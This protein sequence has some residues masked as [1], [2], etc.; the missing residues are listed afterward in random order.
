MLTAKE[1]VILRSLAQ[2]MDALIQIGK[3]GISE[4][5]IDSAS[6]ILDKREL[7][8]VKILRNAEFEKEEAMEQLC[9][10]LH[11]EPVQMIGSVLVIYRR[12]EKKDV[13][14]II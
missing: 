12:S 9:A 7:L 8:K 10:A 13:V 4:N 3:G 11:A 5:L 2:K 1:R 14:H 6:A